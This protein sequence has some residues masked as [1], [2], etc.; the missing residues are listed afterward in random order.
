[1]AG[2]Y[3]HIPYCTQACH[4]CDFHFSTNL[5][6]KSELINCLVKEL[7]LQNNYLEKETV[8]SIYFG[9]GTP[10]LLTLSEV[11]LILSSIT[12]HHQISEEAEI[13]LEANPE[14]ITAEVLAGYHSLGVNRLSV[15]IQS[16]NNDYL[17]LMNRIHTA[18]EATRS[19]RMI[20]ESPIKDFS[21][22]LIFGIRPGEIDQWHRDLS[23]ATDLEPPHISV[24]NLTIEEKTAFGHWHKKGLIKELDDGESAE[25]FELAHHLLTAQ[26]YEHYEISNYGK[27][28]IAVHNSSYW[29]GDK[30]LGIGPG[31]HSFNGKSR[32]FNI[33]NNA[34]YIRHLQSEQIPATVEKLSRNDL[35]NEHIMTGLRTIWGCDVKHLKANYNYD[36]MCEKKEEINTFEEAGLLVLSENSIVLTLKGQLLADTICLELMTS[37]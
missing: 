13:T 24:Y 4:Y 15:G 19:I 21:L 1:M 22:D 27:S 5:K 18:E 31:A 8:E 10:S 12:Q 36:L 28:H 11:E 26:G 35:I 34:T 7:S 20:H 9:G 29:K 30:Y 25:C 6:S 37:A 17:R 2:I 14:N 16:F 32:Q 23:L 33:R 3:I